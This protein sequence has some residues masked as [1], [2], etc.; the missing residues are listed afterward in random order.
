MITSPFLIGRDR[1]ERA[2][3][4]WVDNTH[5]QAFTHTMTIA[6][7]D[8]SV[9]VSAVC[10]PS[11]AY[12]ILE[13]RARV[14]A[15]AADPVIVDALGRLKGVRMVAGFTR[16]LAE[17]CGS[18][19]GAELFVDAGVQIAR[20]ARQVAK[21]PAGRT[22]GLE[23]H[24][25]LRCWL[26]D[27]T[28]WVDLPGSCFTYSAA[29]RGLLDSRPVFTAMAKAL[30]TP[31][32]GASRIFVRKKRARLVLTAR[33]LHLFH[34]MHDN[35]HGFDVHYEV[36]LD[37]KTIVAADSITS[38]L[39]YQ[40]ICNEPQRKI[41]AMIG[42]PVDAPLRKRIQTV[43]GGEAGCAQLYDLTADLLTLITLTP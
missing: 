41:A 14:V 3:E 6:D 32:A 23:G 8:R 39:P 27:T 38:R 35:V 22:A 33:R 10:T 11:P 17:L 7:D 24:D 4:G 36:D 30:Y 9:E 28:G 25:A 37:S 13:A 31:P 5:E 20:L 1:Y 15:G 2:T 19:P 12:E 29:G 18:R 43:L 21:L 42:Q 26:L 40:G 34:S 16:R